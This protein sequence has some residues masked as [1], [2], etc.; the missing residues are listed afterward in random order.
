[1]YVPNSISQ[2]SSQL[3]VVPAITGLVSPVPSIHFQVHEPP[4]ATSAATNSIHSG[5]F[6]IKFVQFFITYYQFYIGSKK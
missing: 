2:D 1:M 3:H 6:W 5:Q 4:P